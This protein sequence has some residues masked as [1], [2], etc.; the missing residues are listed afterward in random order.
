MRLQVGAASLALTLAV[1]L[2]A[3]QPTFARSRVAGG[4]S[5]AG[6]SGTQVYIA[7]P[8]PVCTC[9]PSASAGSAGSAGSGHRSAPPMQR[10]GKH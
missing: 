7:G 4:G 9:K 2:I 8:P 3:S 6:C 5:Q 1:T 10:S